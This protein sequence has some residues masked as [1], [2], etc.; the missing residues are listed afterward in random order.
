MRFSVLFLYALCVIAQA[1][2]DAR[3]PIEHLSLSASGDDFAELTPLFSS[4]LRSNSARGDVDRRDNP[5]AGLLV[6]QSCPSGWGLCNNGR[7]CRLGGRCCGGGRCC[8]PGDFCYASGCCRNS[9]TGCEGV[10]C[11]PANYTCC[12]GGCCRPGTYCA[13]ANGRRGCCQNG[14]I[15]TS[16]G[17]AGGGGGGG[18]VTTT[19]V[20]IP[21]PTTRTTAATTRTI[22]ATT[23]PIITAIVP[24]P[25][26]APG[27]SI[28]DISATDPRITY[29]GSWQSV[30]SSCNSSS[31]SRMATE[32]FS[33]FSLGFQGN[34]V[35]LSLSSYN[36]HYTVTVG[37]RTTTFGG[38][39][40]FVIPSNCSLSFEQ[41]GLPTQ[42][43]T[44]QVTV[45]GSSLDSLAADQ[46]S[47]SLDKIVV[48]S[49]DPAV[50]SSA[51]AA[52]STVTGLSD[53]SAPAFKWAPI[54]LATGVAVV[55]VF[56]LF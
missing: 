31:Q 33:S 51:R 50:T 48:A 47:F 7:C 27:S 41:A 52:Q 44:I 6:R 56:F 1:V 30:A 14:K 45:S 13:V 35:Y 22:A 10:S 25:T 26:P 36:A 29:R 20:P 24:S 53:N 23:R 9:E 2:H 19:R 21:D 11:C 38:F 40:S 32:P 15:C 5:L 37:G 55:S 42:S 17:S 12:S 8:D 54:R 43:N 39:E 3:A 28:V 34:A 49:T 16:G 4:P 18:D 46:W